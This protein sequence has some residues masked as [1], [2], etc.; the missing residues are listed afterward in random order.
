MKVIVHLE[1]ADADRI[2]LYQAINGNA[3]TRMVSRKDVTLFVLEKINEAIEG[4][5]EPDPG[6]ALVTNGAQ[7]PEESGGGCLPEF[8]PSRGDESYLYQ[9][10]DEELAAQCSRF[11]D[12]IEYFQQYT[13][14][15]LERN[16]R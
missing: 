14:K 10:E 2:R 4:K 8:V 1:L 13:W 16:R 15:Q 7:Q 11:L 6:P 9:G 12:S 3:L 5:A